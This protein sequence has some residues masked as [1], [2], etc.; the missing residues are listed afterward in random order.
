VER[1]ENKERF[2]GEPDLRGE[3]AASGA[4]E[5]LQRRKSVAV[6]SEATQKNEGLFAQAF[7]G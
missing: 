5:C 4:E 6:W 7:K 1:S 3:P 2:E